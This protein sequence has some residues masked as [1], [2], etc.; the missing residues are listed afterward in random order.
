MSSLIPHPTLRLIAKFSR[1][2]YKIRLCAPTAVVEH[3]EQIPV[4]YLNKGQT[5]TLSI[6]DSNPPSLNSEPVKY[7]VYVRV[8]FDGEEQRCNPAAYWQLWKERWCSNKGIHRGEEALAVEYDDKFHESNK[9]FHDRIRIERTMIDGFCITWT[10][11]LASNL[12]NCSI[13]VR[14]NFVSTDFQR[15]KGVKGMPVRLGVKTQILAPD[16]DVSKSL[17]SEMC[18]CKVKL[19]RD[20]G[21]ERRMSH[22]VL[23]V[24]KTIAKLELQIANHGKGSEY[25]RRKRRRTRSK[26]LYNGLLCESRPGDNL[27]AEIRIL[28]SMFSSTHPVSVLGL[29]G[30]ATDDPDLYPI[31]LPGDLVPLKNLD[32]TP[33][34]STS[35]E[36]AADIVVPS[37][38]PLV[39]SPSNNSVAVTASP[40]H[41]CLV[42]TSKMSAAATAISPCARSVSEQGI[43]AIDYIAGHYPKAIAC[44]YIKFATTQSRKRAYYHAVYLTER[45]ERCL[46]HKLAEKQRIDPAKIVRVLHVNKAGLQIMVDDDF[47]RELSEGQNMVA[48]LE[49]IHESHSTTGTSSHSNAVADSECTTS[50]TTSSSSMRVEIRLI[51]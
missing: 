32:F 43:M 4:T 40:G 38:P 18:Y 5:Y 22:D 3:A 44:L 1:F 15:S 17:T 13:P 42:N 27:R 11:N 47:V 2:R 34:K 23:S 41:P 24:K 21:A 30:D 45:T 49:V 7:R 26:R 20:H 6:T 19:F 16:V 36:S 25:D 10:A 37:I 51:Y 8:S 14:F 12:P 48:E 46:M 9:D 39:L 33:T 35:D 28:E 29:R 50:T 31:W